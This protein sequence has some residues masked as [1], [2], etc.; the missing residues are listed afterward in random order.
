[1]GTY[2]DVQEI[3]FKI[4]VEHV[5][6][7]IAMLREK[8]Q[9]WA[10]NYREQYP[11]YRE[12]P[13]QLEKLLEEED[14]DAFLQSVAGLDRWKAGITEDGIVNPYIDRK[15]G[16][17]DID[18]MDAMYPFVLSGSFVEIHCEDGL[19]WRE[20]WKDGKKARRVYPIW[21]EPTDEEEE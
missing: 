21:P 5:P 15:K 9:Q 19:V 16:S 3:N 11:D 8:V 10:N 1:M 20:V 7:A 4:P 2:Y 6:A 13:E 14:D 18:W 12:Y 17:I